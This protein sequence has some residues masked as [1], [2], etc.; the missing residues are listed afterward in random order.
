[1]IEGGCGV[2][3]RKKCPNHRLPCRPSLFWVPFLAGHVI[4]ILLKYKIWRLNRFYTIEFWNDGWI[5]N[6]GSLSREWVWP[7]W[8]AEWMVS[9]FSLM[10]EI[11]A[12]YVK[13]IAPELKITDNVKERKER[14]CE[15]YRLSSLLSLS[16][17][18][19]VVCMTSNTSSLQTSVAVP[20]MK[21]VG[22]VVGSIWECC[23]S[24]TG[25]HIP[26]AMRIPLSNPV[27][28]SAC[29]RL[30]RRERYQIITISGTTL[31]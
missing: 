4:V 12:Y 30:S 3:A 14:S 16:Q 19:A 6:A 7:W 5:K 28:S 21:C 15:V 26:Y 29:A 9:F 20:H 10:S 25:G 11:I 13:F 22:C 18:A 27:M 8:P 24:S 31:A 2:M 1:M 23:I 17:S